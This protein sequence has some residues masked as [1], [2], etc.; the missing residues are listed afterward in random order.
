MKEIVEGHGGKI[1]VKS[2]VDKGST[3]CFTLPIK[4]AD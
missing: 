3:F 1:T 2:E 4:E